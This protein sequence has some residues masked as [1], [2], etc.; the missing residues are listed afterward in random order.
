MVES[1][2]PPSP[3][4]ANFGDLGDCDYLGDRLGVASI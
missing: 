3:S 4:L 1:R 2:I